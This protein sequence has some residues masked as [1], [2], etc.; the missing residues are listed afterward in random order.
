M[1]H[2]LVVGAQRT[3]A[4]SVEAR[5]ER[6]GRP[7]ERRSCRASLHYERG[8]GVEFCDLDAA[9]G[10]GDS[11]HVADGWLAPLLDR[12]YAWLVIVLETTLHWKMDS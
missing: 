7:N 9:D 4:R 3:R 10:V 8:A 5:D 11:C 2:G 6:G 1:H 12:L